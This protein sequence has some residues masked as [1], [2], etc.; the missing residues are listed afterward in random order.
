MSEVRK[1]MIVAMKIG[2][3]KTNI[4][5]EKDISILNQVYFKM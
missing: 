1:K 4:R 5:F 3:I 2:T